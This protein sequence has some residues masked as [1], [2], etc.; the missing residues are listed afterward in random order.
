MFVRPCKVNFPCLVPTY[1]FFKPPVRTFDIQKIDWM[2]SWVKISAKM[3]EKAASCLNLLQ[4]LLVSEDH[5][6][7]D[8]I[9]CDWRI[10]CLE[11][12]YHLSFTLASSTNTTPSSCQLVGVWYQISKQP[13]TLCTLQ[14]PIGRETESWLSLCGLIKRHYIYNH[15]SSSKVVPNNP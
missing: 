7:L 4:R 9:M 14:Y 12:N 5:Q 1:T 8:N 13:C 10:V 3:I 11:E 6:K 15:S 2:M